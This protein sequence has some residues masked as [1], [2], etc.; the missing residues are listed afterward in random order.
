LNAER[1]RAVAEATFRREHGRIIAALIRLCGSFDRAEEAMQDAF[2]VAVEQW[3]RE[4]LPANPRTWLISTARFR[5]I[6][7]QR[8][9]A[10]SHSLTPPSRKRERC[11]HPTSG[12]RLPA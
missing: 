9:A 3:E 10:R 4:G 7:R 11:G 6:D 5:A 8:R 2:A 12:R 1:A